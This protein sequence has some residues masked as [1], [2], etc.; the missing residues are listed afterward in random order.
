MLWE[1]HE[2]QLNALLKVNWDYP[3]EDEAK[4]QEFRQLG[5]K[6]RQMGQLV[7]DYGVE[8]VLLTEGQKQG[9]EA[10]YKRFFERGKRK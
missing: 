6:F 5:V 4:R 1:Q 10:V 8:G 9:I 3:F 2:K 7:K